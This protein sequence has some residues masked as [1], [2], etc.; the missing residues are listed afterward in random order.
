M[1]RLK[2]EGK[3]VKRDQILHAYPFCW[4]CSSPLIYRAVGSWFV[5]VEKIRDEIVAV[6][7][8]IKWQPEHLKNGRFGKWL[9]G[10]RDWAISRNR[11]WGNP[12]P[13][14]K[15]ADCGEAICVG[16]REELEK[17]SGIYPED[18]HK[19]FVD[20][21]TIPCKCGGTMKRIPEVLDCWFESG[22]MPYAQNHYPFENKDYFE[23]HFPADFISEGLDQTR[24]V[25]YVDSSCSSSFNKPAFKNVIVSGL[26]LAAD[27]KKCQK[28]IE[29]IQIQLLLSTVW[30]R[31]TSSFPY[32]QYCCKS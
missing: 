26:V 17:F 32:A 19:H 21:I 16:S 22:S 1:D 9:E 18:L 27:G 7:Q 31:C 28:V 8:E 10:A 15:C 14:W 5:R 12:I 20:K 2:N 29:T 30:C 13:V 6:N 24:L 25:L 3:L 4:R 11:Y 23:E